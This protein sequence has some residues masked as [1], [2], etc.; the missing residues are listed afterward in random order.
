MSYKSQT[1]AAYSSNIVGCTN[2]DNEKAA[3]ARGQSITG[4]VVFTVPND[5]KVARVVY[6]EPGGTN[7][8]WDV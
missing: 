4:C 6:S 3:L 1:A 5:V 2:L 8:E 7:G